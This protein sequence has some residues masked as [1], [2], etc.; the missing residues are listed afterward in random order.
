MYEREDKTARF[1]ASGEP[2]DDDVVRLGFMWLLQYCE[3]NR[4]KRA[5][6]VLP[7]VKNARYLDRILGDKVAAQLQKQRRLV[8]DDVTIEMFTQSQPP[9]AFDGPV[10]A[11]W[12]ND[13][14][15]EKL[16]VTGAAAIFAAPTHQDSIAA[17]RA[18]WDPV[19]VR[20]G[21]NSGDG[22]SVGN[23]VVAKGLEYLT[24]G[25]NVGTGLSHPDDRS[26]AINLF[27]LLLAGGERFD[28]DEVRVWAVRHGW[29]PADARELAD[30]A[31]KV[32]H[33]R[34]LRTTGGEWRDDALDML[35]REAAGDDDAS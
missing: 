7:G 20:S 3:D 2:G 17:W 8:V 24:S 26:S 15:L 18:N 35:R 14:S 5:A 33:G 1:Y 16:D 19:D 28:P 4:H 34:Q 13:K 21:Q 6:L 29:D 25:V 32:R 30:L 9:R 31:D 27:R 11:V 12:T 23:P 10:L 22:G